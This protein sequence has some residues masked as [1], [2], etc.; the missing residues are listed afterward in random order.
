M[1]PM[2]T[3][4]VP[5]KNNLHPRA[6]ALDNGATKGFDQGLNVGERDRCQC[7]SRKDCLKRLPVF[8]VHQQMLARDASVRKTAGAA[9]TRCADG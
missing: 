9:T 4:L 1:W 6:F 2:T 5:L 3:P 8:G 7:R